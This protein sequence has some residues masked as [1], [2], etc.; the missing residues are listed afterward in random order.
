MKETK[1]LK[2]MMSM[3]QWISGITGYTIF[4]VVSILILIGKASLI[5]QI[6]TLICIAICFAY[7]V[8]STLKDRAVTLPKKAGNNIDE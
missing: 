3:R 1:K 5:T 2:D 8:Y 7:F 4:F 6:C